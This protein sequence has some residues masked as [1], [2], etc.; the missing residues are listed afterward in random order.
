M[1]KSKKGEKKQ[2]KPQ[3]KHNHIKNTNL[4]TNKINWR[5]SM[6]GNVATATSI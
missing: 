6:V 2:K 4:A 3:Q 5:R 1:Q